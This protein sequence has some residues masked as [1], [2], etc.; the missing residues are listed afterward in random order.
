[1]SLWLHRHAEFPPAPVAD[2]VN[3]DGRERGPADQE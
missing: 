1:M 2:G 3:A